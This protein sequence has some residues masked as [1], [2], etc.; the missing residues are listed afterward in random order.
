M[1]KGELSGDEERRNRE[2]NGP[3]RRSVMQVVDVPK[4]V[5]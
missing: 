3:T 2:L 5:S 4:V 1:E